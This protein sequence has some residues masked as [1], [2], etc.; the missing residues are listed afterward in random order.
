[1]IGKLLLR[2]G[3]KNSQAGSIVVDGARKATGGKA[4][5]RVVMTMAVFFGIYT[6]I[7]GRLVYLGY[8]DPDNSGAPAS[9]VTASRPD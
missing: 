1:M 9:R 5:T 7:A 8:Q 4:K 2:R 3:V 6:M